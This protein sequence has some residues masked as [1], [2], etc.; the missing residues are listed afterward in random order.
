MRRLILILMSNVLFGHNIDFHGGYLV[1]TG[2]YCLLTGG[3]CLLPLVTTYFHFQ[4][5]W[6]RTYL[7]QNNLQAP[8]KSHF[9][10]PCK[11]IILI[12]SPL[13]IIQ[14]WLNTT[15]CHKHKLNKKQVLNSWLLE[16]YHPH[17]NSQQ[18]RNCCMTSAAFPFLQIMV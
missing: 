8:N 12:F 2:D 1:V 4:Y 10:R 9:L 16:C 11:T 18:N 6:K 15:P 13:T 3:Y 7:T 5:E 17:Q 14:H